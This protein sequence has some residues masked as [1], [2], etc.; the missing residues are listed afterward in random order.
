MS[1]VRLAVATTVLVIGSISL[2]A[3]AEPRPSTHPHVGYE[4]FMKLEVR[5]RKEVFA[6]LTPENKATLK[7]TH[8]EDWLAKNRARLSASQIAAVQEATAFLSP[9]LYRDPSNPEMRKK[10]AQLKSQ[11]ECSLSRQDVFDAFTFLGPSP[12]PTWTE[13][14]DGWLSW[15]TDCLAPAMR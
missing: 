10:E 8:A 13:R 11:L 2:A 4:D 9:A 15:F 14:L 5:E 12:E 7:Q 6:R 3:Q 1:S